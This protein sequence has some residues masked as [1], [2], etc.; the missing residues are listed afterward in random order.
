MTTDRAFVLGSETVY[1][2]WGYVAWSRARRGTRFYAVEPEPLDDHH[3]SAP[4]PVDRFDELARRLDRSEAQKAATDDLADRRVAAGKHGCVIHLEQALGPRP[5]T[6]RRRWRWDLAARRIERY[7]CRHAITD[8]GSAL[9]PEP[10]DRWAKVAWRKAQR[11]LDRSMVE[12]APAS[13]RERG[14]RSVGL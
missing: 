13:A 6:F 3:T 14:G 7:R 1:R 12:R 4:P 11:D 9:G 2:E 5:E 8:P 10:V